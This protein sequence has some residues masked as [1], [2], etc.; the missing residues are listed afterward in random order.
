[1]QPVP[2]LANDDHEMANLSLGVIVPIAAGT[3]NIKLVT[4]SSAGQRSRL[5][6]N[7]CGCRNHNIA[8]GDCAG[9]PSCS[10]IQAQV[11]T[12]GYKL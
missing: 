4:L 3:R 1:M 9:F 10:E 7:G 12:Y 6:A 5:T 11:L 8:D 2:V